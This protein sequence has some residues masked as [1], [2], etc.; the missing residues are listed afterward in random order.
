[1]WGQMAEFAMIQVFG[2]FV[3]TS[4]KRKEQG[5]LFLQFYFIDFDTKEKRILE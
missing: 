3:L 1:M 4:L 2:K 5:T